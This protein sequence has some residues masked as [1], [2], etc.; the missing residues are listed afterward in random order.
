MKLFNSHNISYFAF[1]IFKNEEPGKICVI[2][3][4]F[5]ALQSLVHVSTAYAN[6]ERDEINEFIYP[7]PTDPHKLIQMVEWMSDDIVNTITPE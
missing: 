3:F 1:K 2:L 5:I 7:P 6:C 4:L